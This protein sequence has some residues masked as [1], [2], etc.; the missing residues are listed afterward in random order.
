MSAAIPSK[1]NRLTEAQVQFF[2]ENGYLIGLPSVYGPAE[3][4][5]LNA[6]YQELLKYLAA[7]RR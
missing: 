6:G 5:E 4:A 2:K 1:R 3:V 7:W